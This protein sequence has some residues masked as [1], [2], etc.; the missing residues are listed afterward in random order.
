[1]VFFPNEIL[2][3]ILVLAV[4]VRGYKRAVRLRLVSRAWNAAVEYAAFESDVLDVHL[5]YLLFAHWPTDFWPRFLTYRALHRTKRVSPRMRMVRE[6]AECI[7][8]MRGQDGR[9]SRASD[10]VECVKDIYR[11]ITSVYD[12]ED[13]LY[14]DGL[15]PR[16][17]IDRDSGTFRRALVAA[18]T[19]INDVDIVRRVLLLPLSE[20]DDDLFEYPSLPMAACNGNVG[21]VSCLLADESH[22]IHDTPRGKVLYHAARGNQMDVL[23]YILGPDFDTNSPDF[24]YLRGKLVDSLYV[25]GS[26]DIFKRCFELVKDHMQHPMRPRDIRIEHCNFSV[27]FLRAAEKGV[28][29][30]MKYISTLGVPIDGRE[31]DGE[32]DFNRPIS[33]AAFN[34]HEDAV[35]WLLNRE[36]A[37]DAS[38]HAVVAVGSHSITRLLIA[39]GALYNHK[40]VQRALVETV[41]RENETLF[42]LL[43]EHG[44]RLDEEA[45]KKAMDIVEAEQLES[46]KKLLQEYSDRY[47]RPYKYVG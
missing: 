46:M 9:E 5:E 25:T 12:A 27:M 35:K 45:T 30:L 4:S 23:E 20:H 40:V 34:G 16:A 18:A 17:K 11:G 21:V 44:A 10:V 43:V 3:P 26:V 38:L 29:P 8:E 37:L 13:Q 15:K 28:V 1:M 6:L 24:V 36:A 7:V 19:C 33:V 41:K 31:P 39:H 47:P 22:A 32:R 2:H 42:W 14:G